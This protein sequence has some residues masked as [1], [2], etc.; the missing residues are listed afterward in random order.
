MLAGMALVPVRAQAE[1]IRRA[2]DAPGRV[3]GIV[4]LAL[5]MARVDPVGGRRGRLRDRV[6]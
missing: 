4:S 3:A 1:E 5:G 6:F 2:R